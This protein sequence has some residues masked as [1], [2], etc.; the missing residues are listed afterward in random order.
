[1][2]CDIENTVT[3]VPIK[4]SNVR[5]SLRATHW[6]AAKYVHL[7][8]GGK[9]IRASLRS[10]G[11]PAAHFVFHIRSPRCSATTTMTW[12]SQHYALTTI[13]VPERID[14]Q[15]AL[16]TAVLPLQNVVAHAMCVTSSSILSVY[17]K[18]KDSDFRFTPLAILRPTTNSE[19]NAFSPWFRPMRGQRPKPFS[20]AETGS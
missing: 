5:L 19:P 13:E 17:I 1:M 15:R 9:I 16:G 7:R 10:C 8:S 18:N 12:S 6:S 11:F 14:G 20:V 2:E 4:D 3:A